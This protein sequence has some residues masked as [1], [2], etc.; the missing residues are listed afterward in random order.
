MWTWRLPESRFRSWLIGWFQTGDPQTEEAFYR[1]NADRAFQIQKVSLFLGVA[2][3]AFYGVLDQQTDPE[4]ASN[5]QMI[6]FLI[7]VPLMLLIALVYRRR[8]APFLLDILI[9]SYMSVASLTIVA[10]IAIGD[11]TVMTTYPFGIVVVMAYTSGFL[12][13]NFRL[14]IPGQFFVVACL[15]AV[16]AAREIDNYVFFANTMFVGTSYAT[17]VMANI[18]FEKR[19]RDSFFALREE[20]AARQRAFDMYEEARAA[21][22]AKTQFLA[23]VSHELRTPLNAIIGFSEIM[24]QELFGPLGNEQYI[25]YT[26]DTLNSGRHLLKIINDIL[27]MSRF[28]L[29]QIDDRS[30]EVPL[31]EILLSAVKLSSANAE[32]KGVGLTLAPNALEPPNVRVDETRFRQVAV[33]LIDNAIK[34][35]PAEGSVTVDWAVAEDGSVSISIADTGIGIAPENIEH[36]LDPFAQVESAFSRD[37]EGLGLGLSLVKKIVEGHGGRIEIDSELD[38]GSTFRVLL[39]AERVTPPPPNDA[40]DPD[41]D[42]EAASDRDAA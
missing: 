20:A 28:D 5:I 35:T 10:M 22:Y 12:V 31:D 17:L 7:G 36:V 2:V 14:A 15:V 4:I 19:A 6:R 39:P 30:S 25:E 11:E 3:Y 1:W 37:N 8:M 13:Q 42:A 38:V 9:T 33:N 32:R 21:S 29:S 26:N 34:F 18:V 24:S 23:T 41:S 40:D 27:D 16:Y